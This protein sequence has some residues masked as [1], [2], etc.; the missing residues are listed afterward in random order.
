MSS[1]LLTGER[2]VNGEEERALLRALG[3]LLFLAAIKASTSIL[4]SSMAASRLIVC[5][6]GWEV[7]PPEGPL[8]VPLMMAAENDLFGYLC[9]PMLSILSRDFL[10]EAG[11]NVQFR[12]QGLTMCNSQ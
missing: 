4:S 6:L 10:S 9:C 3:G 7:E 1:M 12:Y 11:L 2:G 8:Y 5:F